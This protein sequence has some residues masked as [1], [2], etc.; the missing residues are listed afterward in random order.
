MNNG[1]EVTG[2]FWITKQ[3]VP[4]MNNRV[5]PMKQVVVQKG[6]TFAAGFQDRKKRYNIELFF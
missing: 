4:K 1:G 6:Y 5:R 3:D 2:S